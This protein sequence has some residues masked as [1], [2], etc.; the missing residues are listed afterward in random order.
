MMSRFTGRSRA[1]ALLAFVA[2]APAVRAQ[3]RLKTMPGYDQYTRMTPARA[4]AVKLGQVA[5]LW[6]DSGKAFDY[7]LDGKRVRFDLAT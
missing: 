7:T 3:D 1:L 4:G 6:A 5:G 2:I